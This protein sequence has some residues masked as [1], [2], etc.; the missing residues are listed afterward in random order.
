MVAQ[1]FVEQ[2][3]TAD[4]S[5]YLI[6]PKHVPPDTVSGLR[7]WWDG[8]P[9]NCSFDFPVEAG[10][11]E[12]KI[13]GQDADVATALVVP[14]NQVPFAEKLLSPNEAEIE[15]GYDDKKGAPVYIS[16]GFTYDFGLRHPGFLVMYVPEFSTTNVNRQALSFY[17]GVKAGTFSD[18]FRDLEE[19]SRANGIESLKA[20]EDILSKS[21][22]SDSPVFEAFGIKFPADLATIGG[23]AV[24][25][26]VQLYF[27][28]YLRKLYGTLMDSD[29]GW[30]VPWVG[31]ESSG[32][33]VAIVF[34]TVVLFPVLSLLVLGS[35]TGIRLTR[36]YWGY[37]NGSFYLA[38]VSGWHWTV[39]T[40]LIAMLAAVI[41]SMCL[42]L[43]CWKYRPR[44]TSVTNSRKL[45][46]SSLAD[47]SDTNER[48]STQ[49]VQ[50][51]K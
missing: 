23:T 11:G 12:I 2:C 45:V 16:P 35:E 13:T 38:P 46:R 39:D 48:I 20:L 6:S 37:F 24:L 41:T 33:A 29:P 44:V 8:L 5:D 49:D 51:T 19:V 34:P 21:E 7:S 14:A 3:P 1:N 40:K 17:M 43:L 4:G 50:D 27:L 30:D 15:L 10:V 26:G 25:L 42:S 28:T 47:V 36:G 22:P 18:S 31:M 9:S 32:L